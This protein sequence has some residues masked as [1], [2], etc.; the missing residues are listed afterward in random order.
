MSIKKISLLI[1]FFGLLSLRLMA[2]S[3]CN[4]PNMNIVLGF[5]D[6]YNKTY[7]DSADKSRWKLE[8]D[9]ANN[10]IYIANFLAANGNILYSHDT[11]NTQFLSFDVAETHISLSFYKNG[12]I[13]DIIYVDSCKIIRY[14]FYSNGR[15]YEKS[16][17]D[18]SKPDDCT[19]R[20]YEND[21]VIS[22]TK[23]TPFDYVNKKGLDSTM[24][25]ISKIKAVPYKKIY[26]DKKGNII[27][28]LKDI[29]DDYYIKQ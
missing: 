18:Y 2:Q 12:M 11:T 5:S 28:E 22:E 14:A 1:L 8:T 24:P 27:R 29:R 21:T 17:C 7:E 3:N 6:D 26:Y 20:R 4:F 23:L 13:S 16:Y 10:K 19:I 15:I 25:Y 9:S